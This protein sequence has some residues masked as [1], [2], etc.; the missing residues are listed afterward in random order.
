MPYLSITIDV[1]S[2][3][4][5]RGKLSGAGIPPARDTIPGCDTTFK[6]SLITFTY[7]TLVLSASKRSN[8]IRISFYQSLNTNHHPLLIPN[9]PLFHH[10]I[11][12]FN[13][14]HRSFEVKSNSV[15]QVLDF[16]IKRP[17]GIIYIIIIAIPQLNLDVGPRLGCRLYSSSQNFDP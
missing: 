4:I 1:N 16:L 6:I 2:C 9:I 3:I 13:G 11:S 17:V 8:S 10:S 14:K 7:M 12:Y 5:S 15:A